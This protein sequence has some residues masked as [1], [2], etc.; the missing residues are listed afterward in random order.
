MAGSEGFIGSLRDEFRPGTVANLLLIGDE[1]G[2][3]VNV[4]DVGDLGI[5]F[6]GEKMVVFAPWDAVRFMAK[7]I[8]KPPPE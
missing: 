4:I 3:D 7:P 6:K 2:E 1:D 5:L 8:P